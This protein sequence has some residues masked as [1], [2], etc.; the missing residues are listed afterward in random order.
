MSTSTCTG[1]FLPGIFAIEK[2]S[3]KIVIKFPSASEI[4]ACPS[5][6]PEDLFGGTVISSL[7]SPRFA[8]IN[9]IERFLFSSLISRIDSVTSSYLIED[10]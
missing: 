1:D 3:A 7:K 10:F 5:S 9:D 8:L 4:T 2:F 6:L